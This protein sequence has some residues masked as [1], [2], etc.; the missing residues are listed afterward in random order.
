MSLKKNILLN[1][2]SSSGHFFM[3]VLPLFLVIMF[4]SEKMKEDTGILQNPSM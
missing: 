4:R 1:L 3:I 2:I